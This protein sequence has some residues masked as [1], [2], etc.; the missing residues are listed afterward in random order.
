MA[1]SV[2]NFE[3]RND[4]CTYEILFGMSLMSM[5]KA[6]CTL[7][8]CLKQMHSIQYVPSKLAN[9]PC[10]KLKL[11]A[12]FDWTRKIVSQLFFSF[13]QRVTKN[14]ILHTKCKFFFV[15]SFRKEKSCLFYF[16]ILTTTKIF[17]RHSV[18]SIWFLVTDWST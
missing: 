11:H 18:F 12:P 1:L 5:C 17:G 16:W 3:K 8:F 13:N 7:G 4:I 6:H 2:F 9:F 15:L 14:Q 10:Q